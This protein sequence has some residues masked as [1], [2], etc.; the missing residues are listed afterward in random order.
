MA[1]K[2]RQNDF[3][4]FKLQNFIKNLKASHAQKPISNPPLQLLNEIFIKS[5]KITKSADNNIKL[6]QL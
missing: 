5:T 3:D 2:H 1:N 6:V 4:Q